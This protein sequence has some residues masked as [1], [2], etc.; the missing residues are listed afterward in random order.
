M[1]I[2]PCSAIEIAATVAQLQERREARL[3]DP[4]V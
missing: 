2:A 4:P 1:L 3:N